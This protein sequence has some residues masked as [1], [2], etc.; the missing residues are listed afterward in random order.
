[1]RH[2]GQV[3]VRLVRFI[4]VQV[5]HLLA[6][7]FVGLAGLDFLLTDTPT[8]DGSEPD[9]SFDSLSSLAMASGGLNFLPLEVDF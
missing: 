4:P 5:T 1:M 7:F 8:S 2:P 3:G 9:L 6:V